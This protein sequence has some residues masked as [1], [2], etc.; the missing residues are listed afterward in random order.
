MTIRW[1]WWAVRVIFLQQ[2]TKKTNAKKSWKNLWT[3]AWGPFLK[4]PSSFW[5]D[6]NQLWSLL[7]DSSLATI[8]KMLSLELCTTILEMLNIIYNVKKI[9][10]WKTW[11][12]KANNLDKLWSLISEKDFY[13]CPMLSCIFFSEYILII[14]CHLWSNHT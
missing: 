10:N 6:W 12:I 9:I 13:K 3:H 11:F 5:H 7:A 1:S 4:N 14:K 2:K 8:S